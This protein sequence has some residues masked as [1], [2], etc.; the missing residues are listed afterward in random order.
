MNS[1]TV[2]PPEDGFVVKY[3]ADGTFQWVVSMGGT[4]D[5]RV[6]ACAMLNSGEVMVV[7][8]F[9]SETLEFTSTDGTVMDDFTLNR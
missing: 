1:L 7:G 5:E 6:E 8:W 3:D 2:R 4:L 9:T